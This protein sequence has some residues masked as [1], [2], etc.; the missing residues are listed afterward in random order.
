MGRRLSA[1]LSWGFGELMRHRLDRE[2]FS[3]VTVQL[4]K[5]GLVVRTGKLVDDTLMA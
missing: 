1:P 2:L 5:R 3:T 4:D